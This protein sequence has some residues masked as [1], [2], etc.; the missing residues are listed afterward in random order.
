MLAERL[1]EAIRAE[2][3]RQGVTYYGL[4]KRVQLTSASNLRQ[5]ITGKADARVNTLDRILDALDVD[6][7]ITIRPRNTEQ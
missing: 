6:V 7:E 1:L 3:E 5:T 4:A 2:M